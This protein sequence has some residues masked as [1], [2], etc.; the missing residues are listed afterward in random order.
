M[1]T[2]CKETTILHKVLAKHLPRETLLG[3]MAPVFEDYKVRLADAYKDAVVRSPQG[4]E[5]MVADAM[6]FVERLAKLEGYAGSGEV[7]LQVANDKVVVPLVGA[8]GVDVGGS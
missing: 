4:K 1:E 2:L 8:E 3:I 7:I 6:M 5:R